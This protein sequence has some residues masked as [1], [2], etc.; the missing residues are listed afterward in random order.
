MKMDYTLDAMRQPIQNA[1]MKECP[2]CSTEYDDNTSFCAREG[3]ALVA[4][5]A[6]RTR[7]CPYCA[8]S[9][10]DDSPKCPYCKAELGSSPTPQWPKREEES[11]KARVPSRIQHHISKKSGWILI[12]GLVVFALGVFL[13]GSQKQRNESQGVL[14]QKLTE[15]QQ[16]EQNIQ[17]RDRRIEQSDQKIRALEKQL[18]ELRQQLTDHKNELASLKTKLDESK[19]DLSVAQQRL[20]IANREID[21]LASSRT[22]A[23]AKTPPRPMDQTPGPVSTPAARRA[24]DPGVYETVRQTAV[25]EEPSGSGRV[26]S[27]ISKGTKVDVVR[28]VGDWLEVRS[29]HGNPSGFIRLDD[30]IFVSKLN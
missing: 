10:P 15:L 14:Q 25:Y 8:N 20:G 21:R 5:I 27:R 6:S 24:T 29:K 23:V 12:A 3:R 28:S 7:L 11:V 1:P 19:R 17:E 13:I 9:I 2:E 4:K 18:G 30:A 22:Q 16:K 26:L